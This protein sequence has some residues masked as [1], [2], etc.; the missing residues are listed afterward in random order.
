LP[1]FHQ[2][3]GFIGLTT[4]IFM[5]IPASNEFQKQKRPYINNI[6]ASF[7][8]SNLRR[9]PLGEAL[10]GLDWHFRAWQ[11]PSLGFGLLYAI[12]QSIPLGG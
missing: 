9:A 11:R 1:Y 8:K 2:H 4:F 7:V 6:P 5:D 10:G 3:S 12:R